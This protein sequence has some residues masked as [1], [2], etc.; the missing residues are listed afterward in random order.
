VAG[1]FF[2]TPLSSLSL[3]FTQAQT[4]IHWRLFKA[5]PEEWNDTAHWWRDMA[6]FIDCFSAR[7]WLWASV[8][9]CSRH[10]Q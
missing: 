7:S 5:C 9:W 3:I 8:S 10:F 1:R 2:K 6:C 4:L